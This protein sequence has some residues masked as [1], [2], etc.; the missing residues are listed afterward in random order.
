MQNYRPVSLL[1]DFLEVLEKVMYNRFS[2]H[3]HSNNILLTEQFGFRQGKSIEN[4]AFKITNSVLRSSNQKMNGGGIF[5][6]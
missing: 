2:H 3:K 4:A 5:C 6:D 1:M